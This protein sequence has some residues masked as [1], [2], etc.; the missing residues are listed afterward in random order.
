MSSMTRS[1]VF[2][3]HILYT[4]DVMGQTALEIL[5]LIRRARIQSHQ[6]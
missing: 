1:E 6:L 2:Y 5:R 4:A 3:V